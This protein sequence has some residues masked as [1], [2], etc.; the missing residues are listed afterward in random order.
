MGLA[1]G[2]QAGGLCDAG[3]GCAAALIGTGE[4]LTWL[5]PGAS[6]GFVCKA[7]LASPSPPPQP[8]LPPAPPAVA[9]ASVAVP[10]V[11]SLPRASYSLGQS[12]ARVPLTVAFNLTDAVCHAARAGD[13]ALRHEF[14]AAT[15][16]AWNAANAA[17]PCGV[18]DIVIASVSLSCCVLACEGSAASS[19]LIAAAVQLPAS[20]GSLGAAAIPSF[21]A[22]ALREYAGGAFGATLGVTVSTLTVT[23]GAAESVAYSEHPPPPSAPPP[24]SPPPPNPP[25]SPPPLPPGPPIYPP[26]PSPQ[27]PPPAALPV[28]T[29]PLGSDLYFPLRLAL[30]LT[31]AGCAAV[32]ADGGL[33][34]YSVAQVCM[35]DILGSDRE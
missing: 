2:Y 1:S 25:P 24:P 19:A 30:T 26:P 31:A 17:E 34:P 5:D 20:A 15:A 6:L 29:N 33:F 16:R 18:G 3:F 9:Y 32:R 14:Q 7:A 8:P 22:A 11:A 23:A 21:Q 10:P 27:P 4:A 35:Y 28:S 13:A 12:F